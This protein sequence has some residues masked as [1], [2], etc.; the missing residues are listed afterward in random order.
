[1]SQ[2]IIFL[3]K[4]KADYND[5]AVS[6]TASQASSFA[7]FVQRRSNEYGWMTTGSVD[8]DNTTLT[9]DFGQLQTLTNIIL[10]KHNFKSFTIKYYDGASYQNFSTTIAETV[11]TDNTSRFSFNSVS[12]TKIQITIAGT[13]TAN[14]EKQLY[15]LIATELLGQLVA[16]PV[17]DNPVFDRNKRNNRMLSGKL[18][19]GINSGAFMCDLMV[20][21]WSSS[22]D[23]SLIETLYNS[24]NGFLVWLCGGDESQ[25]RSERI[26]YRLEDFFLMKLAD[27]YSPKFVEGLYKTGLELRLSLV[28]VTN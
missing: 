13:Q 8:A 12:T 10:V 4:N 25:F 14:A 19:I 26:G 16:W 15:Q 7:P 24:S 21:N 27:N 6:V 23:L 20:S 5:S 9:C 18:N 22:A 17:I 28:E 1:M 3:K 2:Q 11:N